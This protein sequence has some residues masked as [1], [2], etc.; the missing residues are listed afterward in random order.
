[1]LAEV[2]QGKI[3]GPSLYSIN[4]NEIP[5]NPKVVVACFADKAILIIIIHGAIDRQGLSQ[6][7]L[8]PNEWLTHC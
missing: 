4:T 2:L 6:G 1:M 8:R 5:Q 7:I 3:P